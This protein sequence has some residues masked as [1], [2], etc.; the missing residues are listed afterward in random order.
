[1]TKRNWTL[2]AV[3]LA[4]GVIYACFFTDWFKTKSIRILYTL[5]PFQTRFSQ[6]G[7]PAPAF[8]FSHPFKLTEIKVVPLAE[9]QTNSR[10]LPLWHLVS[11]SNSA[12]IKFFFYGARIRGLKPEVPAHDRSRSRPTSPT[13]SSS[14][15]EKSR[16]S[17]TSSSAAHRVKPIPRAAEIQ[18]AA[19]S[20]FLPAKWH[21]AKLPFETSRNKGISVLHFASAIGQRG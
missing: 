11:D 1:M 17:T 21:A 19:A 7:S 15:L 10:V 6:G 14:P 3:A 18:T 4:L 9:F 16:A 8:G 20:I 12:P 2:V 5:P 13:A